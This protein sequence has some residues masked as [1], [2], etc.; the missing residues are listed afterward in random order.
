MR[1]KIRECMSLVKH[2]AFA[3][4]KSFTSPYL[5]R[6]FQLLIG[7]NLPFQGPEVVKH[8]GWNNLGSLVHSKPGYRSS[9]V[10]FKL[11]FMRISFI[12]SPA[13]C[14]QNPPSQ[15]SSSCQK[16]PPYSHS[17]IAISACSF[18]SSSS[19]SSSSVCSFVFPFAVNGDD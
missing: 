8:T 7:E 12:G 11:Y 13:S 15:D 5:P 17:Y 10:R 16:T 14:I 6:L 4:K 1:G 9:L 2:E 19:S 18:R 3:P